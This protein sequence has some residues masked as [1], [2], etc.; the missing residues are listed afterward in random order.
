M[1]KCTTAKTGTRPDVRWTA[2]GHGARRR[3]LIG[4]VDAPDEKAAITN[5]IEEYNITDSEQQK[6]LVAVSA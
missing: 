5:A 3:P 2:Y 1:A 6:R 4:I